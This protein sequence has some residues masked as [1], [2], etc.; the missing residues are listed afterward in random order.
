MKLALYTVT[1]AGLWYRGKPLSMEEFI[2][3]AAKYGFNGIEIDGKRPHGF[4]LDLDENRRKEIRKMAEAKGLEI[5]AIA[6]NNNFVSPFQEQRE[7]ELLMLSEQIKLAKDLGAPFLR[8]FLAWRGV[9]IIDGIAN[10][11]TPTKYDVDHLSPDAANWQRWKWAKEALQEGVRIAEKNGVTMVL[12][13]HGPLLKN[14]KEMISTVEEIGSENLK[15]CLDCM[16]LKS[17][18]DDYVRQAV[19][20][21]GDLQFH[22]HFPGEFEKKNG[23]VEQMLMRGYEEFGLINYPTFVKALKEIGYKGYMSYE[24]CHSPL[25]EKREVAGIERVH[26]QVQYAR[27]YMSD[28]IKNT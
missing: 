2:D 24:F 8:V 27:E 26:E 11:E 3:R 9:T 21:V 22:S 5:C 19:L 16:L 20:D 10:Y 18:D 4:P 23:K 25:N 14:Y 7:N 28:L 1:Y 12:Q 15:C 17:Q 13:N 6:G